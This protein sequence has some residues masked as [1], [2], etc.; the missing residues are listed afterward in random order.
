MSKIALLL[1]LLFLSSLPR[2]SKLPVAASG[3][4]VWAPATGTSDFN[5]AWLAHRIPR[6][7]PGSAV[8]ALARLLRAYSETPR[9]AHSPAHWTTT[10]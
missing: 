4:L 7:A 10:L 2:A 8:R 5:A 3:T 9:V 6:G 1:L